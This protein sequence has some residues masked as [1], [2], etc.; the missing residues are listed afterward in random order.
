MMTLEDILWQPFFPPALIWAGAAILAALSLLTH[1]AA[2][3]SLRLL[4]ALRS[5]VLLIMRLIL[6]AALTLLLLGPSRIPPITHQ[7]D[8]PRL[9][10]LLDTSASMQAPDVDGQPRISFAAKHWL[11]PE[12]LARWQSSFNVDLLAFDE[13]RRPLA[14]DALNQPPEA[15]A[16]G[17][18][19]H[20]VRSVQEV[21]ADL[22]QAPPGSAML[23]LSDGHDTLDEPIAPAVTLARARGIPIHAV[24]LGGPNLQRD[25]ALTATPAQEFLLPGEPGQ[26]LV[27]ILHAHALH[28]ATTLHVRCL[29]EHRTQ[30]VRF[31][32]EGSVTLTLPVRHDQSGLYEYELRLDPL[33]GEIET[34]NNR[35]VIFLQVLEK[36]IKVLLLEGQPYW[37]T[38]F[39]AQSLRKDDRIEL[40]QISQLAADRQQRI[41]TR[42]DDHAAA[43]PRTLDELAA[44]DLII[45]GRQLE[46]LLPLETARLL[47]RY[48]A[49]LGGRV[50][51]ARSRAYDPQTPQGQ[52]L[53][54][55]LAEIEPVVWGQGALQDQQVVLTPA[56]QQH[57]CF[58]LLGQPDA[59]SGSFLG[60][61]PPL[62]FLPVV[63]RE[64]P[65][66]I[67]LARARPAGL[68]PSAPPGQPVI[69]TMPHSRGMVAAVLGEGLWRW[70][71]GRGDD[72]NAPSAGF[73]DRFWSNLARWLIMGS[74]FQPGQAFAIRLASRTVQ[75]GHPLDIDLISR[76]LVA[77]DFPIVLTV[78]DPQGQR[79]ALSPRPVAGPSRRRA[80]FT[81]TQ[82]GV[83]RVLAQSPALTDAPLESRFTAY[84]LDLERLQSSA[85]PHTL[86][87]LAQATGGTLLNPHTPQQLL[88]LLQQHRRAMLETPPQP[89]FIWNRGWVLT[90]LLLWAGLE[91][92]FRKQ[93]GLL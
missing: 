48:V 9:T 15:L 4:D 82:S 29:D 60:A 70:S 10:I 28:T 76:F 12:Q 89:Q 45:L 63:E 16:T 13:S 68:P 91:W 44:Y 86:G 56:G 85:H 79:H 30:S 65:T 33:P 17:Q 66:A 64:K 74:D 5:S 36:R 52:A 77:E 75:V 87:A 27:K 35:Q 69:V 80:S 46:H 1:A 23:L 22:A 18:V 25:I 83:Y 51:F 54:Q 6:I 67:V 3:R 62:T 58:A 47:P 90:L 59:S 8:S 81:P 49:D 37:D 50:I 24:P 71:L 41:I 34:R 53:A 93:G 42:A 14:P 19:T 39:I 7:P 11:N 72:S 43:I 32:E 40:T 38:K 84:D 61:L 26:I 57:P 2:W 31:T 20:L 21:L 73:F 92:L 55:A 78:E 88:P